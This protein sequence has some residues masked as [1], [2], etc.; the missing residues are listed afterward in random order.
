MRSPCLALVV[1]LASIGSAAAAPIPLAVH[2]VDPV[3]GDEWADVQQLRN[4]IWADLDAACPAGRQLSCTGVVQGVDITGWHFAG[5]A[6]V[7]H[8]FDHLVPDLTFDELRH[9]VVDPTGASTWAP[10]L[11]Q[12]FGTTFSGA[13]QPETCGGFSA[14]ISY[15]WTTNTIPFG[16][17]GLL[18]AGFAMIRDSAPA[19]CQT[20]STADYVSAGR[21]PTSNVG[22]GAWLVRR[23]VPEPASLV[24]VGCGLLAGARRRRR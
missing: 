2:V 19:I 17:A 6:R 13:F 22:P 21:M 3:T 20:P 24:L 4:V 9:G 15:G 16:G 8:L 5:N 7:L 10:F 12:T 14:S 1:L 18:T 23:N 11:M